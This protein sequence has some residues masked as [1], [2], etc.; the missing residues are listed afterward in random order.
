LDERYM[1][2]KIQ[3]YLVMQGTGLKVGS[4]LPKVIMD[5]LTTAV[6]F[7]EQS[8]RREIQ[9]KE[10]DVGEWLLRNGGGDSL[11]AFVVS[12]DPNVVKAGGL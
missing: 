2:D 7:P 6:F 12:E 1:V 5:T 3:T 8:P 11:S 9:T 4:D 10:A